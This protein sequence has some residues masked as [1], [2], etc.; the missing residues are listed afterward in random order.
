[1]KYVIMFHIAVLP[2]VL[3]GLYVWYI[4][5]KKEPFKQL[6]KAVLWGMA[7]CLPVA[8]VEYGISWLLFRGGEP[9]SV[10]GTTANAFLVA[11][12]PEELVKLLALWLALRKNPYFDEHY[13][14]VVYAVCV[15]LGFAVV[16]NIM[17]VFGS[18]AWLGVGIARALLSVPGHYAFAVM[19]GFYY[20]LYH[21]VDRSKLT[22]V[23][24]VLVPV[25]AH[26]IYD[27]I[28]MS[29]HVIH[30]AIAVLGFAILIY[31]CIKMQHV[32]I[33]KIRALIEKDKKAERNEEP[34]VM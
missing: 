31:F 32:A 8:F 21:F 19:M 34:P 23:C 6:A 10:L 26:G 22:A 9:S 16:E 18:D 7:V 11:A 1:M 3:L 17:Y 27:A 24:I 15:G 25:I 20:S 5:P 12:I 33:T 30:P 13:D 29:F 28:V 14:G 4:D 2:A